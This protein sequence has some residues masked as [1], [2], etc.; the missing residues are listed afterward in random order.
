MAWLT[1]QD[2]ST[3]TPFA[4]E[5]DLETVTYWVQRLEPVIRADQEDEIIVVF[6]N[7]CGTEDDVVYAGSSA[8]IGIKNGTVSVYGLLGRGVKE[9]LMV[10]TDLPP[11]ARLVDRPKK[12]KAEEQPAPPADDHP[13]PSVEEQPARAS[14]GQIPQTPMSPSQE[15]L[16]HLPEAKGGYEKPAVSTAPESLATEPLPRQPSIERQSPPSASTEEAANGGDRQTEPQTDNLTRGDAAS[17]NE[18]CDDCDEHISPGTSVVTSTLPKIT[19]TDPT[20]ISARPKLSIST[21]LWSPP[22]K[23]PTCP[24][25]DPF[26]PPVSA[27]DD[28]LATSMHSNTLLTPGRYL[29]S[30]AQAQPP[31]ASVV[32]P[33]EPVWPASDIPTIADTVRTTCLFPKPETRAQSKRPPVS[34]DTSWPKRSVRRIGARSLPGTPVQSE[35]SSGID[36]TRAQTSGINPSAKP[37]SRAGSKPSIRA[38]IRIDTGVPAVPSNRSGSRSLPGTPTREELPASLI[39]VD[40]TVFRGSSSR[41]RMP[42]SPRTPTQRE[43]PT[44]PTGPRNAIGRAMGSLEALAEDIESP[45]TQTMAIPTSPI[46]RISNRPSRRTG[47][48]SRRPSLG[49]LGARDSEAVPSLRSPRFQGPASPSTAQPTSTPADASVRASENQEDHSRGRQSRVPSHKAIRNLLAPKTS[50]TIAASP[51]VFKTSFNENEIS[52]T[53]QPS[54]PLPSPPLRPRRIGGRSISGDMVPPRPQ[55]PLRAQIHR[56]SLETSNLGPNRERFSRRGD[57]SPLDPGSPVALPVVEDASRGLEALMATEDEAFLGQTMRMAET[58][59]MQRMVGHR[60]RHPPLPP[61]GERIQPT[62]FF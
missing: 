61:Q 14:P 49:S 30:P 24:S 54:P 37:A 1:L 60:E 35:N 33:E 6:C 16:G 17:G 48:M 18:P 56:P 11:F 53:P 12:A 55:S 34:I 29:W 45:E 44:S 50:I 47:R 31:S 20:P 13:V 4:K 21:G 10:D 26:T 5:P 3:F 52:M 57:V 38:P 42:T 40:T 36:A 62:F 46:G 43:L 9:L 8:V 22:P 39:R 58:W 51:S 25:C 41:A 27:G 7:R 32:T 2:R 23:T 59:R 15:R 19:H 28:K